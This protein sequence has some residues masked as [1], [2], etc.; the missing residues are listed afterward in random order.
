[1]NN[2]SLLFLIYYSIMNKEIRGEVEYIK[3]DKFK[4]GEFIYMGMGEVNGHKVCLSV[5]YKIDYCIKKARQFKEACD[6]VS[7]TH[8]NKVKVGGLEP[9]R[10]F[11]Y[12]N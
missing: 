11:E 4:L 2:S 10:R 6:Q 1:M 9:V 8:I 5:A 7:F 3:S 12:E